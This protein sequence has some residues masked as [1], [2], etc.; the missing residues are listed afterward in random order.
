MLDPVNF[1]AATSGLIP[2]SEKKSSMPFSNF[3]SNV[4]RNYGSSFGG[5]GS[6]YGFTPTAGFEPIQSATRSMVQ[7][8]LGQQKFE[9]DLAT[10]ALN[11]IA[12]IRIAGM[13]PEQPSGGGGGG[14]AP[15]KES[16]GSS[17]LKAGVGA[18]VT[19]GVGALV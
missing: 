9:T 2:S 18:A 10:N 5:H 13:A 12:N 4:A 16:F 17:L 7:D 19:A 8:F 1:W 3:S 14:G 15:K 6:Q 11:A